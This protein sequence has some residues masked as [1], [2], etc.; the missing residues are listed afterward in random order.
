M[1]RMYGYV[2]G[3]RAFVKTVWIFTLSL[4]LFLKYSLSLHALDCMQI[5]AKL[6]EESINILKDDN[7]V[8]GTVPMSVYLYSLNK[9]LSAV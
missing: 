2:K 9:L 7:E 5:F 6:K 3:D 4:S 8:N 1:L